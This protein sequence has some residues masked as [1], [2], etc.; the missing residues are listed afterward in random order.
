[1][2]NAALLVLV[3]AGPDEE[4]GLA[5]LLE[6]VERY[7]PRIGRV[8]VVDDASSERDLYAGPCA[9]RRL[10][11]TVLRHPRGGASGPKR[12]A[13]IAGVQ[14]GLQWLSHNLPQ[15]EFV[16][17]VDVDALVIAPF[18][19]R[20][21]AFLRTHPNAGLVGCRGET[22]DRTHPR[23]LACLR[24]RSP[25][26]LALEWLDRFAVQSVTDVHTVFVDHRPGIVPLGAPEY[27]ALL[28]LRP[29]IARAVRNGHLV[30][31]YCQ[32]GAYAISGALIREM[33]RCDVFE[34]ATRW[35]PLAYFGEDEVMAMYCYAL[36]LRPCDFSGEG[37]PFGVCWRGLPYSPGEL[38]SRKHAVIHSL[39]RDATYPE[40]ESRAFFAGLRRQ[41]GPA[42]PERT[43][44]GD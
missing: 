32:G 36:G 20:I 43:C 31:D 40:A 28:A 39:K 37:Q 26:A 22:C 17:K 14:T 12:G 25:F 5:E 44:R 27:Q 16:L 13:L 7:E 24:R 9:S 6:S 4:L 30:A 33:R 18:C 10:P 3:G 23:Y 15:M 8:V 21:T 41:R 11:I 2:T 29:W 35:L 34:D 42:D 38:A 1:M 19:A